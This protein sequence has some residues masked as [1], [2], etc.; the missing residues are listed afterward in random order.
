MMHALKPY[1]NVGNEYDDEEDGGEY[2]DG[3]SIDYDSELVDYAM[4]MLRPG[5]VDFMRVLYARGYHI[6]L[7]TATR[8]PNHELSLRAV[9]MLV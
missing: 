8:T 1:V 5:V 7:F 6:V 3:Y 4:G 2:D 9:N